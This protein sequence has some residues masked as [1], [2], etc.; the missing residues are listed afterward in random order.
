MPTTASRPRNSK[1]VASGAPF[2]SVASAVVTGAGQRGE[3]AP[4]GATAGAKLKARITASQSGQM[5]V[6]MDTLRVTADLRALFNC[7]AIAA[8]S[9]PGWAIAATDTDGGK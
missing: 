2:M 6:R 9:R 7:A 1:T 4:A 5:V 8:S 3:K